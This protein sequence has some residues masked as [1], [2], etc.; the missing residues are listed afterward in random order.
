MC[1]AQA[2]LVPESR[3][4]WGPL[5]SPRQGPERSG[6]GKADFQASDSSFLPLVA[7]VYCLCSLRFRPL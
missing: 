7:P 5:S 3:I 1:I 2:A 4:P 6:H